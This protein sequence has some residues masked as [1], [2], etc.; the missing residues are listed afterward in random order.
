M[1]FEVFYGVTENA[2]TAI[3]ANDFT[4]FPLPSF[5]LYA[6]L[7]F[8]FPEVAGNRALLCGVVSHGIEPL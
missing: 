4:S 2:L 5:G 7:V 6:G 8:V 3:P 1:D